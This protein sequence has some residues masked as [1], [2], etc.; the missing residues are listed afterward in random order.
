MWEAVYFDHRL[1]KLLALA[2]RAAALGIE[3]FVLDDGW[4]RHRRNDRA[5]LGDWYVD[6]DVWPDG[7]HPLVDRVH[8]LGMEFGLWFE[9]EMVNLDSDLARAHPEW[10]LQTEHGPGIAS[11]HQ[12]VLDLGNPAA[13]AHVL[14]RMSC[15]G[16]RV[17]DRLRQVG[18]QPG[19]GRRRA[20]AVGRP[21]GA[22][23]DRGGL[24][25]DG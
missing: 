16:G 13:Y 9:P 17:P 7:L 21:G 11:R 15:A 8:A 3:R 24:P 19:A 10:I 23:P 14:D 25:A 1:D 20:L 2:E 6:E 4:F 22:L 5:G 18:P 12:H